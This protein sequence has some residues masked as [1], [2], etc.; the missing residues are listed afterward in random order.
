M[1]RH[2]LFFGF[3]DHCGVGADHGHIRRGKTWLDGDSIHFSFPT[4]IRSN[5]RFEGGLSG[6]HNCLPFG[7]FSLQLLLLSFSSFVL[8]V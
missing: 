4:L 5:A 6:V 3:L 7:Y 1:A 8:F 2:I